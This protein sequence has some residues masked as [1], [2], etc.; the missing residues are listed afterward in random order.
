MKTYSNGSDLI[1]NLVILGDFILLNILLI[2]FKQ[3]APDILPD[4]FEQAPKTELFVANISLI[5]AEYFFHTQIHE[6]RRSFE[7]VLLRVLKLSVC[8]AVI[9]FTLSRFVG[10][11]GGFFRF[12][13]IYTPVFYCSVLL[14]RGF[15]VFILSKYRQAGGN[16]RRVLFIGNDM[17]NVNIY[18]DLMADATTGYKVIG[19]F[20]DEDFKKCP[21]T[22]TRLGTLSDLQEKI[23][24]GEPAENIHDVFCC[25]SHDAAPYIAHI[26]EWCD[27]HV[28]HFFYVPRMEGNY[29]LN[30]KPERFGNQT[31]F[32]NFVEPLSNRSNRFIK[33]L[34]DIVVSIIILLVL[35][36]FIPIIAII[37]KCQSPGPLF[38]K[39][40]RTGMNGK[41][42]YCYK[43]RSM[44]VNKDA[45]KVQATR[46]DPR[47]FAFGNFMRKTNIDEFPQF[48]NVL[49]GDMSI[50]GPRPH[51]LKH[52]EVYSGLINKYMVRHFSKP[53]ITGWAQ[54]TGYRGETEELWQMEERVRR[55]IWYI[56]NWSFWLDIK[57]MAMTA[58]SIIKP[59]KKAY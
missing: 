41:N 1:R 55:D 44:H 23:D 53:G 13:F 37:I 52:T 15:E 42:F 12:I 11:S 26:I 25:L 45:D 47:K 38:F 49:K 4:F 16:T 2:L 7:S 24:N 59:D 20:A 28:I 17:A 54:V 36:P 18:E 21:D 43:F 33:R 40:E 35:L 31:L 46:D 32:T 58:W 10:G 19:Y 48:F 5:I 30:L 6:R 14:L 9:F 8:H 34:F 56:E 50:V 29:R 22:F 39:Q 3:I 27:K 51:M 57:I